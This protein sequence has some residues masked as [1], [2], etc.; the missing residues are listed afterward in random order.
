[1]PT[2]VQA[3]GWQTIHMPFHAWKTGGVWPPAVNWYDKEP[4]W[5]GKIGEYDDGRKCA[6]CAANKGEYKHDQDNRINRLVVL[7][8]GDKTEERVVYNQ[9]SLFMWLAKEY[10][11][12]MNEEKENKEGDDTLD[13]LLR[14]PIPNLSLLVKK[15]LKEAKGVEAKGCHVDAPWIIEVNKLG[16]EAELEALFGP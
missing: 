4:I 10:Q 6:H 1:M 15:I 5:L 2:C 12:Q 9:V 16:E 7:A 13:P 3:T 8:Y 14:I 11:R